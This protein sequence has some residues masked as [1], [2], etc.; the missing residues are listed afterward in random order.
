MTKKRIQ[1]IHKEPE[2]E[3]MEVLKSAIVAEKQL[4]EFN[5]DEHTSLHKLPEGIVNSFLDFIADFTLKQKQF[6]LEMIKD[7]VIIL[8]CWDDD[9]ESLSEQSKLVVKEEVKKSQ[10]EIKDLYNEWHDLDAPF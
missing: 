6:L 2:E 1:L 3:C 8:T 10:Q 5:I 9:D 7:G 4:K